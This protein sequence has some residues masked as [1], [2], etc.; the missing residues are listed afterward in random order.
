MVILFLFLW[1]FAEGV[2][3]LAEEGDDD[4]EAGDEHLAGRGIPTHRFDTELQTKI[5]DQ[6]IK[7]HN[8][9]ITPQLAIAVQRRLGERD[10]TIEPETRQQRDGKH[11]AK[12]GNMRGEAKLKI[13][14]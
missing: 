5:V 1:L 2:V 13:G 4:R 11:N 14:D 9:R 6:Q 8:Q 3:F 7:Q 10:I 12:R